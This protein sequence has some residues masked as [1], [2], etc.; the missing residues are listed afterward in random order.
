MNSRN[1]ILFI[2][3]LLNILFIGIGIIFLARKG[4]FPYLWTKVSAITS[5]THSFSPYHLHK[6]SQFEI[7]PKSNSGIIFLGDSLTDEGEWV[8]LLKNGNIK[9]RGISSDTTDLVLNRLDVIV[10]SQPK[11]IFLMIGIND[12]TYYN[13][14]IEEVLIN[15]KAILTELHKKTP[16]TKVFIQSVL[17]VNN[18]VTRFYQDNS[19]IL[20]LNSKLKELS[21][22]F[23]YQYIDVFSYLSD[24]ENQLDMKY[25]SDGL[26]LNGQGYLMWAKV[27]ENYVND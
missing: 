1:L 11:K 16:N 26:H 24:S 5:S 23:S 4:G 22:E 18:Q 15:Y 25:T 8:E 10:E 7:L 9:N 21:I 17:P 6:K 27:I 2:S 19:N 3:L 13:K 20:K 12:I 14:F